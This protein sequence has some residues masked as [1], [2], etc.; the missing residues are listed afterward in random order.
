MTREASG[1]D[2][3]SH[4]YDVAIVGG[5]PAGLNAALVLG[6]ACR[7]TVVIDAGKPRNRAAREMHGFLSRDGV[8]PQELL[9]AGR[10]EIARYG[11][12]LREDSANSAEKVK[13]S[14]SHPFETGFKVTTSNGNC[15]VG[16]KL[17]LSTGV[18]D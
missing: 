17:L 6:R 12:D 18:S 7:R 13:K 16:R 10:N 11:V 8:P 3:T 5:G 2:L 9:A 1:H 15:F 4:I 14:P